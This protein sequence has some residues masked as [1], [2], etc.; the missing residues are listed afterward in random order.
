MDS[1]AWSS[2]EKNVDTITWTD[3]QPKHPQGRRRQC[4]IL[5]GE[6][7]LRSGAARDVESMHDAFELF[8]SPS[9][10]DEIVDATNRKIEETL[11]S[12]PV[13]KRDDTM[14][15]LKPTNALE[16]YAFIGL[17]YFCGLLGLNSHSLSTIFSERSGHHIFG[18]TMSKNR[19]AFL[20]SHL[21]FDDHCTRA[22]R[23]KM[24]RFCCFSRLL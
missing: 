4:D 6:P 15:Y 18:G 11:A 5:R 14:P 2:Q 17:M 13:E 7:G 24:D 1:Q 19:F 22:E 23:W 20:S 10:E 8:I 3:Q 12:I 9:M 21:C 16:I